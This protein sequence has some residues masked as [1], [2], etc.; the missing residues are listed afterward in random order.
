MQNVTTPCRIAPGSRYGYGYGRRW[1]RGRGMVPAHRLAWE[2]AHGPI[3][4]G[5]QVLHVCDNPPCEEITH[6]F[7]GTQADN[8]HDMWAKN[9][10]R[11][12]R[13][14]GTELSWTKLDPG[15][16]RSIRQLYAEGWTQ[17]ALAD[18]F[19]VGQTTISDIV[20]RATWREVK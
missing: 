9:R 1:V 13:L 3:P 15:R 12:G 6:L 11:P 18:R 4:S 19:Q 20:R 2:Q 14:T 7:L 17:A 8:M 10:A 16:V 5:Q